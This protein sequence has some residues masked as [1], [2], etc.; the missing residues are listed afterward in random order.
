[1]MAG[2]VC[3]MWTGSAL[4]APMSNWDAGRGAS[5]GGKRS[6]WVTGAGSDSWESSGDVGGLSP[7]RRYGGCFASSPFP[8]WLPGRS[9]SPARRRGVPGLEPPRFASPA[10]TCEQCAFKTSGRAV[11]SPSLP[12]I[13]AC[14]SAVLS[15]HIRRLAAGAVRTAS[16]CPR[17]AAGDGQRPGLRSSVPGAAAL[18]A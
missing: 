16:A 10:G 15:S 8:P 13:V 5:D 18:C 11:V 4:A 7:G 17:T 1:M 3:G 12:L 9:A 6:G 14:F 2:A